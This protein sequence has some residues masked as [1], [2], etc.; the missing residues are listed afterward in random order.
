MKIP[1]AFFKELEQKIL[2][3]VL[4]RKKQNSQNNLEEEEQSWKNHGPWLY[5]ILQS[6]SSRNSMVIAKKKKKKEYRSMGDD[7]K[8]RN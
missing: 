7:R 2:K 8:P 3:S 6:Y 5:T 4:S 1:M